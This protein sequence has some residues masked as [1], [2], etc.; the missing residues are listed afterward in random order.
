MFKKTSTLLIVGVLGS[1]LAVAPALA[2]N[3]KLMTVKG[4]KTV[5]QRA[6]VES[7]I[8]LKVKSESEVQD[9]VSQSYTI[10]AKTAAAIKGV[11]YTDII[12]DRDKDIAQVTAQIRVGRVS[13]IIGKRIDY[14]DQ[15]IR[16]VG[17]ATSTPSMAAPLKAMRAAELDAYAQLAEQIVGLKLR[18]ETSVEDYILRSDEIKT[19]MMAAI[20]GAEMVG[21]R[22]D[23][24]GDAYVTLKLNV[25]EVEDVLGQ[26]LDYQGDTIEVEGAGASQDDFNQTRNGSSFGNGSSAVTRVREGALAIP[27]LES[28]SD[29]NDGGGAVQLR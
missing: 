23:E 29:D 22:W 13:N 1:I 14:G 9:M 15:V 28:P 3:K 6:I 24:E 19:K 21:Y 18:S 5:A 20:Y 8:G 2:A 17:F 16:R 7:V 11:E 26:R 27:V 12:Y 25:H 10:D 4:A